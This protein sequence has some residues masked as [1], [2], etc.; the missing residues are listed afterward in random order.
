M[1]YVHTVLEDMPS[2]I[3]SFIRMNPDDG[4]TIVI[5]ARLSA[6]DRLRHYEHEVDHLLRGDL[7]SEDPADGIEM[8]AHY[9]Q[10]EEG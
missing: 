10:K 9:G 5:N 2:G 1:I 7:D 6:E 3:R 4:A 8:R